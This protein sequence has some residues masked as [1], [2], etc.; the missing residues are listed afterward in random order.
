MVRWL[1]T[2]KQ[3]KNT[4]GGVTDNLPLKRDYEGG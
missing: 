1:K 4:G 3:Q 2:N